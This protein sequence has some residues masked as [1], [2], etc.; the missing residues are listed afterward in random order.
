MIT[1]NT[2]PPRKTSSSTKRKAPIAAHNEGSPSD[3][4]G[5]PS[6]PATQ[7][8]QTPAT[9]TSA[10]ARTP[11]GLHAAPTVPPRDSVVLYPSAMEAYQ[12]IRR[13]QQQQ[14]EP[15]HQHASRGS[16]TRAA[17]AE[18][19][20]N[21]NNP[22]TTMNVSQ[23]LSGASKTRWQEHQ[24][25]LKKV[26]N[27]MAGVR[28]PTKGSAPS[29]SSGFQA[30]RKEGL[31]RL[32][33]VV[34][35]NHHD[36]TTSSSSSGLVADPEVTGEFDRDVSEAMVTI[37]GRFVGLDPQELMGSNGLRKLVAR[38]IRWFQNTPDWLK[39]I[40]LV[41]A[42][43]LN[44][45]VRQQQH[46]QQLGGDTDAMVCHIDGLGH[47]PIS[48][49][50]PAPSIPIP[51]P[52]PPVEEGGGEDLPQTAFPSSSLVAVVSDDN[53]A[54]PPT[55]P[56]PPPPRPA[57]KQKKEKAKDLASASALADGADDT[58]MPSSFF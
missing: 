49:P 39:L 8:A 12:H 11:R 16:S 47:V 50:T 30:W 52:P 35:R 4:S 3:I 29:S 20:N 15:H 13:Q 45:A 41:V 25:R 9:Q 19:S 40:G 5:S 57:K 38:N 23:H 18:V 10:K 33:G 44:S 27:L 31:S 2:N 22:T 32:L 48:T 55:P 46:Q 43:R 6:P 42:K 36:E 24:R 21:N 7:S 51:V 26:S 56:P 28:K 1:Q 34:S 58:P 54:L 53:E 17:M 14:Q 37:G